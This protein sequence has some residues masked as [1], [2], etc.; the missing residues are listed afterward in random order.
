LLVAHGDGAQP[1]WH[2]MPGFMPEG[3]LRLRGF[4]IFQDG[5]QSG[6][7]SRDLVIRAFRVSQK[8]FAA[9]V[10]YNVLAQMSGDALRSVI[11]KENFAVPANQIHPGWQILQDAADYFR[12]VK[13]GHQ[14]LSAMASGE[15]KGNFSSTAGEAKRAFC[16]GIFFVSSKLE[17]G[18]AGRNTIVGTVVPFWN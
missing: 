7:G 14:A 4:S 10:T 8:I 9:G 13:P 12:I 16:M 15:I 2:E 5:I 18:V 6:R 1:Y 3:N 11:P 17:V